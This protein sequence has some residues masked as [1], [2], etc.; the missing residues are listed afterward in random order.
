[1]QI[2]TCAISY[3]GQR[4][5]SG[6]NDKIFKLWDIKTG[7]E[8]VM[9]KG[10]TDRVCLLPLFSNIFFLVLIYNI[11]PCTCAFALDGKRIVTG[12]HDKTLKVWDIEQIPTLQDGSIDHVS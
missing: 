2:H 4:V 5:I 11:Q 6:S 7:N 8:L 1:M 10:H 12:A 9:L 3:D